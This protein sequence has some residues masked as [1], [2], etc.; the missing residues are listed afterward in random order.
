MTKKLAWS[1]VEDHRLTSVIESRRV[2]TKNDGRCTINASWGEIAELMPNRS[3]KQCRERWCYNLNP[4]IKRDIWSAKEDAILVKAQ[5]I[6][7]NQW[8]LIAR[9]LPGRTENSVKTRHKSIMRAKKRA[10]S[11]EEDEVILSM[12]RQIGSR[13]EKIAERLPNRTSNGV[14]T[15]FGLLR[16]GL[17][18]EKPAEGSPEQILTNPELIDEVEL[19]INV[20][21]LNKPKGRRTKRRRNFFNI[22]ASELMEEKLDPMEIGVGILLREM[23]DQVATSLGEPKLS[24]IKYKK[25]RRESSSSSKPPAKKARKEPAQPRA[26][27]PAS[28]FPA[29]QPSADPAQQVGSLQACLQSSMLAQ[30]QA[31]MLVAQQQQQQQ[32]QLLYAQALNQI[33]IQQALQQPSSVPMMQ[34]PLQMPGVQNP[35]AAMSNLQQ[36]MMMQQLLYNR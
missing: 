3:A 26:Q 35:M 33:A 5:S 23:V 36:V 8:A 18:H 32:Q 34:Q 27:L 6:L 29:A 4:A 28:P 30:L 2:Y 10:W 12:H 22:P 24:V 7:G 25:Q 16:K 11:E 17:A 21:A 15:R 31:S 20:D 14:K 19:D 13:W 9:H 1:A